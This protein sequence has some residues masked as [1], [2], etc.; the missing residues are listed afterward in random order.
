MIVQ[1]LF[2]LACLVLLLAV[3]AWGFVVRRLVRRIEAAHPA[4]Y[5]E[6]RERSRKTGARL[7][8]TSEVQAA[9]GNGLPLPEAVSMDP[10]CIGLI[11]AEGRL[12]LTMLIAAGAAA[13]GFLAL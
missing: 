3:L 10:A 11:R 5:R 9:L 2:V 6:L 7:A 1:T 8:V 12:R 4:A 13:A